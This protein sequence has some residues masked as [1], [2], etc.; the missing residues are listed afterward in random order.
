MLPASLSQVP[1]QLELSLP[2]E[3]PPVVHDRLGQARVSVLAARKQIELACGDPALE[4]DH[5]RLRPAKRIDTL[6]LIEAIDSHRVVSGGSAIPTA[7]PIVSHVL[8]GT[9]IDQQRA[10]VAN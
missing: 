10:P 7:L 1:H 5:G 9:R 6:G 3:N 2:V 4:L 8:V